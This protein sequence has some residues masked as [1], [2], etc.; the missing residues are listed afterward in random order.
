MLSVYFMLEC[1]VIGER[2]EGQQKVEINPLSTRTA[3]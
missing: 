2:Q 3:T 1:Q